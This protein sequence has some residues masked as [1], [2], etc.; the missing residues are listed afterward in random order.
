VTRISSKGSSNAPRIDRNSI[1]KFFKERAVKAAHLG[2]V[3]AVIYQDKNPDL[4][5]LRDQAEKGKLLPL[6]N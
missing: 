1:E 2:H 3:Q 4:A 6:L 5:K